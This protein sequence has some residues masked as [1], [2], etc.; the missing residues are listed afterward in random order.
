MMKNF[1]SIDILMQKKPR[2]V[3]TKEIISNNGNDA[4]D[5]ATIN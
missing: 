3:K 4:Q 2:E 1:Y 5:F